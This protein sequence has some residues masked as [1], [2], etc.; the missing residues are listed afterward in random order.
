MESK[1]SRMSD[2]AKSKKQKTNCNHE[3]VVEEES[4]GVVT[5]VCE[6]CDLRIPWDEWKDSE[7]GKS[8]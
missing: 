1:K 2:N 6:I 8:E 4:W 7:L 5:I 3:I